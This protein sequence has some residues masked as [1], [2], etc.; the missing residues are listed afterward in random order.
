MHITP[1]NFF[2]NMAGEC[3]AGG[4]LSERERKKRGYKRYG[5]SVFAQQ[6]TL[7]GKRVNSACFHLGP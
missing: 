4:Y 6:C 5:T 7:I 3:S 1:G 2:I